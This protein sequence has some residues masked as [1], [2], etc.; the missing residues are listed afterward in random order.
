MAQGAEAH[1]TAD[2]SDAQVGLLDQESPGF[3]YP[4]DSQEE[5]KTHAERLLEH[6]GQVRAAQ[7]RLLREAAQGDLFCIMPRQIRLRLLKPRMIRPD[8]RKRPSDDVP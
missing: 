4:N 2:A 3:L 8:A 1:L 6:I 7:T 5:L